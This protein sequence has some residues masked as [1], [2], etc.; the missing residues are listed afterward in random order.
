M[1]LLAFPQGARPYPVWAAESVPVDG[2]GS[3]WVEVD[4]DDDSC[5]CLCLCLYAQTTGLADD[6]CRARDNRHD[7]FSD[8]A[9]ATANGGGACLAL[10]DEVVRAMVMR[11]DAHPGHV[12]R[13]VGA[14]GDGAL[15]RRDGLLSANGPDGC[16]GVC[17]SSRDPSPLRASP[18]IASVSV[19]LSWL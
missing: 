12:G 8:M 1:Q 10:R 15:C 4:P 14:C 5:L 2:D 7:D 18:R 17:V 13:L 9:T 19:H 6:G 16:V 3:P 11:G